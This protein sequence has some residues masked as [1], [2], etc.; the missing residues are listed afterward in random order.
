M[1]LEL[2]IL[3][4]LKFILLKNLDFSFFTNTSLRFSFFNSLEESIGVIVKDTIRENIVAATIVSPNSLNI[5]PTKPD[6]SE[7]GANTTTSHKVIAIAA[8]PTSL[9]PS[10]AAAIGFFPISICRCIF[11]ITTIE[12]STRVPTTR[13]NP[14][15]DNMF[16]VKCI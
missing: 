8:I 14:I 12:S 16:K 15:K 13:D 1:N 11:S 4:N 6:T 7:T 9:R 10:M 2:I 5:C 3:I